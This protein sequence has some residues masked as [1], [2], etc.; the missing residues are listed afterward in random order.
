MNLR[1]QQINI[2][3]KVFDQILE[4]IKDRIDE[5]MRGSWYS[6]RSNIHV[7]SSGCHMFEADRFTVS[8]DRRHLPEQWLERA[9][10][11]KLR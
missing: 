5:V 4:V 9:R 8:T 1:E 2:G 6:E 3:R 7:C 11:P 10:S